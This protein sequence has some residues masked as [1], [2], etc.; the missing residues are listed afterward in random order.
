[1]NE[2]FYLYHWTHKDNLPSIYGFG[3]DPA[4]ATGE[5]LLVWAC[6]E[7]RIG[8]ALCHI[9]NR[10]G[11]HPDDM[12]LIRLQFSRVNWKRTSWPEVWVNDTVITAKYFRQCKTSIL[13]DWVAVAKVVHA[14]PTP[15]S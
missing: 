8:W 5:R 3:L 4:R 12:V 11:W 2:P 9:A 7:S 15:T 1:M 14:R 13:A 6:E 10:H